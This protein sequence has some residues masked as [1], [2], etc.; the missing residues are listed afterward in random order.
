MS[1]VGGGSKEGTGGGLAGDGDSGG[2]EGDGG[3]CEYGGGSG[4]VDGR[5]DSEGVGAGV[6]GGVTVPGVGVGAEIGDG[7]GVVEE[8]GAKGEG[9]FIGR[10]ST[11]AHILEFFWLAW[12][13]KQLPSS[14]I[15]PDSTNFLHFSCLPWK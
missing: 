1:L 6:G 13:D 3:G 4:G 2:L 9:E 11:G 12:S 8:G 5:V 15:A 7:D 14:F 10:P